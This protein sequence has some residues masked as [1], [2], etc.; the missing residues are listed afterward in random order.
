MY[1]LQQCL[2]KIGSV[3]FVVS[4]IDSEVISNTIETVRKWI[5]LILKLQ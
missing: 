5:F 2:K 1:G 3:R 4:S